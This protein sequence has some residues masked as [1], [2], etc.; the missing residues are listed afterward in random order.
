[1]NKIN[2]K[3]KYEAGTKESFFSAF[4]IRANKKLPKLKDKKHSS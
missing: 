3:Y 1:M 2:P 4:L